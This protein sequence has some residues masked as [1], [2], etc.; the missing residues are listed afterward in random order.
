MP[1]F[2][3]QFFLT[4]LAYFTLVRKQM[5]REYPFYAVFILTF[6][7]YLC[8]PIMRSLPLQIPKVVWLAV[9]SVCLFGAGIPAL[10]VALGIQ[11]GLSITRKS[12]VVPF[13]VGWLWSLFFLI[14]CD[15]SFL[16]PSVLA[17]AGITVHFHAAW[18]HYWQVAG[19][20]LM[21]V[22]PCLYLMVQG[23][24]RTQPR[25][26]I[27][28][29][30]YFGLFMAYGIIFQN[31]EAFYAGSG[32]SALTWA[33]A[34]SR[35]LREMNRKLEQ[36]HVHQKTLATAQFASGRAGEIS[37][38]EIYPAALD[39]TYPF[40]AR[41]N[42]VEMVA[43]GRTDLIADA[44]DV[45][46]AELDQFCRGNT[47]WYKARV[48]EVLFLL[49]DGAVFAGG[50]PAELIPRLEASGLQIEAAGDL[51]EIRELV[52][53]ESM[54]IARIISE[55]QTQPVDVLVSQAQQFIRSQYA[56]DCGIDEIAAKLHVS[57][58]SLTKSFKRATGQTVNQYLTGIRIDQAKRLLRLK[59]VTEAA[60]EVGFNNSN[61]FST[62]FKK[63]TG[64]TPKQFQKGIK[65]E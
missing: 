39:E 8:G 1:L 3:A 41:Q 45:L 26:F 59:S 30:L 15:Y 63:Q 18:L 53:R 51:S 21:L 47:E 6:V 34:V 42:L 56:Q 65:P 32:V 28:G 16:E 9:R 58:S 50:S 60:F 46:L 38:A 49:V 12:V 57:R 27:C 4:V 52:G 22:V 62:V 7:L 13:G 20:M 55:N 23:R 25:P 24:E 43:A 48:R 33:W 35:D 31:F 17:R 36:Y 61:Y 54:G 10:L 29:A 44:L 11:S 5:R 2:S 40:E 64:Q 14:L 37:V 19:V